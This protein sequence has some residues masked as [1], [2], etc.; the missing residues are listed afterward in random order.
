MTVRTLVAREIAKL[1]AIGA[2]AS[3]EAITASVRGELVAL[4]V[5]QKS[6]TAEV[7]LDDGDG[8]WHRFTLDRPAPPYPRVDLLPDG[9]VLVVSA[10]CRRRE[11]NA[12]VFDPTGAHRYAFPFGDGIE[13][14]GVDAAG[15]I[16]VGY[17]EQGVFGDDPIGAAGLVRFSRDGE[18]L[19][20]Y[21]PPFG[22]QSIFACYALNVDARTTWT[23]Y[24]TDFPLVEITGGRARAYTPTPV[25]GA[26]AV[27]VHRDEAVFV[28]GYD[29]PVRISCGRL[30]RD[31][32]ED[33]GPGVLVDADG[34]PVTEFAVIATR[35]GRLYLTAGACVLLVDLGER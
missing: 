23:Y 18:R 21:L 7:H 30:A 26:Q 4:A 31:A 3:I 20:S 11:A 35:G 33:L 29:E 17:F 9:E 1:P 16:W 19:W 25:R 12:H 22:V 5:E 2:T 15:D 28:G 34:E 6:R 14:V 8:N 27:V 13:D 10:R 24:H 32:V